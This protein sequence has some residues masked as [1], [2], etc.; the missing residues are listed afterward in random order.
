MENTHPRYVNIHI[1]VYVYILYTIERLLVII[2][3]YKSICKKN[4]AKKRRSRKRN[5]P[6]TGG[7]TNVTDVMA[8]N[9]AP[10]PPNSTLYFVYERECPHLKARNREVRDLKLHLNGSLGVGTH[11]YEWQFISALACG[12]SLVVVRRYKK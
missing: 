4:S 8:Q 3:K 11:S 5:A 7:T 12:C 9:E 10:F 1:N 6:L 2:V